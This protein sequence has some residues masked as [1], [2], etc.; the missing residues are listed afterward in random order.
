MTKESKN[1]NGAIWE[2]FGNTY[3]AHC[4]DLSL[5]KKIAT[6]EGCEASSVYYYPDGHREMDVIFP[7][8]LYNRVAEVLNLPF[9]EKNPQRVAQGQKMSVINKKHRFLRNTKVQNSPC[10]GVFGE[11]GLGTS[12]NL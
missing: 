7:G 5:A 4:R 9:R 6:W 12:K 2:F 8:K 3:K 10:E 1:E 11:K